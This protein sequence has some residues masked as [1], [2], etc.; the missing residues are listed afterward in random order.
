MKIEKEQFTKTFTAIKYIAADGTKFDHE[1]ECLDYE[2]KMKFTAGNEPKETEYFPHLSGENYSRLV[3]LAS[4]DH[5]EY[6]RVNKRIRSGYLNTDFDKFGE[7]WYLYWYEDGGDYPDSHHL[8]N[9]DKFLEEAE[10]RLEIFKTSAKEAMEETKM[11]ASERDKRIQAIKEGSLP[12]LG[13]QVSPN[14]LNNS[15]TNEGMKRS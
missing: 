7:G 4:A 6:I 14:G 5:V 8:Y 3:Y 10:Q 13:I 15:Q 2:R 11:D 12:S 9:Y 1:L